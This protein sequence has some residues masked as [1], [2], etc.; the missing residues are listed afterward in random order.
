MSF[1]SGS[2]ADF[3][4]NLAD[5]DEIQT[6]ANGTKERGYFIS[7]TRPMLIELGKYAQTARIP[8][9]VYDIGLDD[10]SAFRK[11]LYKCLLMGVFFH[12]YGHIHNGD[13]DN[14]KRLPKEEKEAEAD[15]FALELFQKSCALQYRFGD[16]SPDSEVHLLLRKVSLDMIA[17]SIA[18][19]CLME[20]REFM[21]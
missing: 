9:N 12:E 5:G 17:F 3:H 20:L 10:E 11:R 8:S 7:V 1:G 6:F 18:Q 2:V 4:V 16:S 21:A 13:C 15:R 14:P 19:E